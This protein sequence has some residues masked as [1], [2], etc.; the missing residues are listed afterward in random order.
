MSRYRLLLLALVPLLLFGCSVLRPDFEKPI[1]QITSFRA[2]PSQSVVPTFEIGLQVINPN[3]F[4]LHLKGVTYSVKLEGHRV[5]SGASNQLPEIA[6][7]E[8][9]EV[10]LQATPDLLNTISLFSEL[11]KRPRETVHYEVLAQ[12]DVGGL[13]PKI[14]LSKD[15]EIS[16]AEARQ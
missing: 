7:Y 12:L 8:K 14:S 4:P 9:G 1:V 3:S 11:I 16:L 13:L 15:G 5:L 2:L 10:L 6:A